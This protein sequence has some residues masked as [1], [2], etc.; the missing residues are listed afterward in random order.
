[1][2][3]VKLPV[4]LNKTIKILVVGM[5]KVRATQKPLIP[6]NKKQT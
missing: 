3:L 4:S 5:G 1:M 2:A 6:N